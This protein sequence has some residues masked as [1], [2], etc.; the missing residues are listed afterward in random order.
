MPM[1]PKCNG[2][3]LYQGG[4][5][6]NFR[7]PDCKKRFKLVEVAGEEVLRDLSGLEE[8]R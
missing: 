8:A 2:G 4:D 3:N 1:C 7:C 5:P 6:Y